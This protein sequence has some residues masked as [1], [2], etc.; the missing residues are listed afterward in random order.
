MT[1]FNVPLIHIPKFVIR[2]PVGDSNVRAKWV[3]FIKAAPNNANWSPNIYSAL[4]VHHFDPRR[5]YSTSRGTRLAKCTVPTI[6]DVDTNNSNTKGE[7]TISHIN[8]ICMFSLVHYSLQ[9]ISMT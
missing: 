2:I 4:C 6:L 7:L 3:E 1:M 8:I 9:L 5:V